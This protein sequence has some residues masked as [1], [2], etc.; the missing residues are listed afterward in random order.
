MLGAF[1]ANRTWVQSEENR[2]YGMG[3]TGWNDGFVWLAWVADLSLLR[4]RPCCP[5][6]GKGLVMQLW[7]TITRYA[8]FADNQNT[9]VVA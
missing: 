3:G 7:G 9:P 4:K 6:S 2:P 1:S 5:V 8:C